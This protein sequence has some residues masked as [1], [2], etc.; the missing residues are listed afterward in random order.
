MQAPNY[1]YQS[2]YVPLK[3]D[4]TEILYSNVKSRFYTYQNYQDL[5]NQY[6]SLG[7]EP[8]QGG[9]NLH[10]LETILMSIDEN[11]QNES[12]DNKFNEAEDLLLDLID[13]NK[14]SF[15]DSKHVKLFIFTPPENMELAIQK[16]KS[17]GIKNILSNNKDRIFLYDYTIRSYFY[18]MF[19]NCD[20]IKSF[21]KYGNEIVLWT[22][23]GRRYIIQ[24]PNYPLNNVD[25]GSNLQ[26]NSDIASFT[27]D[28]FAT[29]EHELEVPRNWIRSIL[30]G[31]INQTTELKGYKTAYNISSSLQNKDKW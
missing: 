2:L 16:L 20:R 6:L 24:A 13:D 25:W 18:N 14:C 23:K 21:D 11:E 9:F 15:I 10:N 27:K 7:N 4:N 30:E 19:K 31:F 8:L 29:L 26:G 1:G 3:K 12:L 17:N 28:V 5:Y 22:N